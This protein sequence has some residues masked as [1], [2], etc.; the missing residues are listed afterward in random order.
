[1]APR[2]RGALFRRFASSLI[3]VAGRVP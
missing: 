3:R 2:A 1:V